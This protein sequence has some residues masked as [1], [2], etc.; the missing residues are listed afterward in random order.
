MT[1]SPKTEVL[2]LIGV[3]YVRLK[4]EDG[5]DLYLT[6][7]GAP[8]REQL[9]P[10]NWHAPDWFGARR[11][12]LEGTSAIYRVPTKPVRGLSLDLVVRFNRVG[13]DVPLDPRTL[14][15]TF[16]IDFNSPFEEFALVMQL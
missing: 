5:G 9:N 14:S 12:R 15:Q 3:R 8:F 2:S 1:L 10:E 16:Q 7:F 6:Q 4:T 11:V 13:Q